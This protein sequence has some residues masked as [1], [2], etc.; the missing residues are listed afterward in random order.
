[1]T[2]MATIVLLAPGSPPSCLSV[3]EADINPDV[4]ATQGVVVC[5]LT[6]TQ[7]HMHLKDPT[8]F[9]YHKHCPLKPKAQKVLIPIVTSLKRQGILRECSSPCN[10]LILGIP[11]PNGEWRLVQD[12]QAINEAVIPIHLIVSNPYMLLAQI[13]E[14]ARW[15]TVLDLKDAF[16]CIPVHSDSQYRFAFEDLESQ[17]SQLTWTVLPR[18]FRDRPHLFGQAFSRDLSEFSYDSCTLLQYVDDLLL[19]A[20]SEDLIS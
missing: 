10:T 7:V 8:L 19:C 14:T 11:K 2:E 9:P 4:W 3:I 5:A 12:L 18:G 20:T 1:M 15:F 13:S 17:N 6:A 16:L